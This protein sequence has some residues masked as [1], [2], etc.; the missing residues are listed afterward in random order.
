MSALEVLLEFISLLGL[1]VWCSILSFF[2][3]YVVDGVFGLRAS[4]A[5]EN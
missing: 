3:M 5:A 2:I 1:L 4:V